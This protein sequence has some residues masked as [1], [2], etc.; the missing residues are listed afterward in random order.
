MPIRTAL[1]PVRTAPD[2][3][4]ETVR[5]YQSVTGAAAGPTRTVEATG[6]TVTVVGPVLVLS[7]AEEAL[8][9][10]REVGVVFTV[11]S[12]AGTTE[13][14]LAQGAE[15]VRELPAMPHGRGRQLRHPD[16][17]VAEY[18]ELGPQP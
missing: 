13:L 1:V 16:G 8:A 12:L 5:L 17:L 3:H 9:A 14:L 6:L 10:E 18:L 11:D 2:R 7:G 15:L 4:T